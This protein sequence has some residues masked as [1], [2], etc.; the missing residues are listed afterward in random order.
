MSKDSNS[1]PA[2]TASQHHGLLHMDI[3]QG[4]RS[5]LLQPQLRTVPLCDEDGRSHP[6]HAEHPTCL[7]A[8]PGLLHGS[9]QPA[10]KQYMRLAY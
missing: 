1:V 8:Q 5:L 7:E 10:V 4:T 3:R 2:A 9:V 6:L